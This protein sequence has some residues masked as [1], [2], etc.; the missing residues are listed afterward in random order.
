MS[1]LIET[2]PAAFNINRHSD[3]S[4]KYNFI[5]S[6]EIMATF[7]EANWLPSETSQVKSRKEG[8]RDFAKHLIRF[9]NP[10]I[11]T[12]VGGIIPEIV[13]LNSHDRSKAFELMA[14]LFRFVCANGMIVADST[15]QSIKTR[16]SSLAPDRITEGI[17]EIV[18]VVPQIMA[19]VDEMMALS[20]NPVDQLQLANNVVES[21]WTDPKIRP[22]EPAQLLEYRR[23]DDN[24]NDL[25]TSYN[26]IQENLIKGGLVGKTQTNRSKVQRG[27]KNIDKNVSVNRILWEET[28][29]FLLAA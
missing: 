22:L 6:E 13:M 10:D 5:S 1:N 26:R 16:H 7:Q 29:R 9:R 25:W 2:V 20:L 4:E 8:G 23:S 3:V 18:D 27:I 17:A 28:D 11:K 19:K 15:F 12:E 21:V 24:K 14:G